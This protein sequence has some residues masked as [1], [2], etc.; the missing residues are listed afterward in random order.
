MPTYKAP[1]EDMRFVLHELFDSASRAVLPGNT[2]F[3]R[4]LIDSILG[5]ASRL[6]EDVLFPLNQQGDLEGCVLENGRVRTPSGFKKAYKI[7][8]DGGWTAMSASP[9]WGGQAVPIPVAMMVDE[10]LCSSNV[11]F[12]LY[13]GLSRGAY[14][15]LSHV[16]GED[17]KE[18]Y[19]PNLVSGKWSATMCLTEAHC[20]TD[21]GMLRT[22]AVPKEDGSYGISG[23]KIFISAGEHDLTE[24][25]IHLVLARLP[26]APAGVR[27]ISM[28]LVPKFLPKK[29][30][31]PGPRNGVQCTALEHKMGIHGSATC[32]MNF[33]N[34]TGWL[35]GEPNKGLAGMFTMMNVERV[36]V[37]MQGLGIAEVAYQNAV[38]YARE[39][40]QGRSLRGPKAP[41]KP[42]DPIIVHPDIRRMLLT[43]R[44]YIEGCRAVACWVG[45]EL[46]V[47]Q[48]SDDIDAKLVAEDFSALMTPVVKA[49]FTD[50]GFEIASLAV[51]VYGGHGYIRDHG[52]EQFLRDARISMLYEGTNGV[53]AL[54]LV[55]RKLPHDRGRLLSRFFGPV[56]G[57]IEQQSQNRALEPFLPQLRRAVE[58]LQSA[59]SFIAENAPSNHDEAGAASAEYL[60]LF[61]LVALAF[62]WTRM[63]S[64]SAPRIEE[65]GHRGKFYR[66]KVRT[67]QFFMDRLLPQTGAL[68]AAI[69][70][71]SKIMME[72]ED[73]AF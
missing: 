8:C 34:A 25:I 13:P 11:A 54:D 67:A 40:L 70:S 68:L 63:A 65:P 61:G 41:T 18:I 17:L 50:L 72:F 52:V 31:T 1:L 29:D 20:G 69:Q 16:G 44:A 33:D 43:M 28:F 55:T 15:A 39:R 22:R 62:V 32:T 59:T 35:L 49:L 26:D 5:H 38:L 10:M 47:L 12:A 48:K 2:D 56:V 23:D 46:E 24:N 45:N 66:A 36:A 73:T 27:G 57:F 7:F 64:V 4:D 42:A 14:V 3:S 37:G 53:Q 71:G 58:H 51:Q 21:L 9:D 60:R 19:L 6:A 30:G